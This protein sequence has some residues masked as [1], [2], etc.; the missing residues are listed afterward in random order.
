M[1]CS[2]SVSTVDLS[3][4][5]IS[6]DDIRSSDIIRPKKHW[7]ISIGDSS[8]FNRS[9]RYGIWGIDSKNTQIKCFLKN[10]IPGDILWFKVNKSLSKVAYKLYYMAELKYFPRKR[11]LGPLISVSLTDTELGWNGGDWDYEIIYFKLY[12]IDRLEMVL[13]SLGRMSSCL[14]IRERHCDF[15]IEHEYNNIIRY[16]QVELLEIETE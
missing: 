13:K 6:L 9:S 15:S 8:N 5:S 2:E 3:T 4:E 12:K 10:A 14:E 11:E 1:S 7:M 16:S